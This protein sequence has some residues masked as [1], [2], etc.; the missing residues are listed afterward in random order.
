MKKPRA[1]RAGRRYAGRS[2]EELRAERR[3]RLLNAAYDIVGSEGYARL[4]IERVCAAAR[5]AT[6]HYYEHFQGREGLLHG[7]FD[8][9]ENEQ[10]QVVT[11][12]LTEPAVDFGERTGMA[13]RSFVGHALAD[14]RR[15]RIVCLE[16]VGISVE[17]EARRRRLI[18]RFADL[19]D[20][21]TQRLVSLGELPEA[22]Y[23]MMGIAL[24]GATNEL[25]VEWL[26]GDSHLSATHMELQV[27]NLFRA[28]TKG[29]AHARP[30]QA[31][32][33]RA[34]KGAPRKRAASR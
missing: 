5:V 27:L 14:P 30:A 1:P 32:P 6:R 24:V 2:V 20:Q 19:I 7:L 8:R 16:S 29:A 9:I 4:S 34:A 17:M 33:R 25:L 23:D 10:W 26:S 12:A 15:A 31:P 21:A 22:D 13:I 3:E 28:M 11:K 18:R